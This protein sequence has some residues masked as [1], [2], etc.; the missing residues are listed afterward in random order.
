MAEAGKKDLPK[1]ETVAKQSVETIYAETVNCSKSRAGSINAGRA[2][3]DHSGIGL[4]KAQN[5]QQSN[6]GNAVVVAKNLKTSSVR[7]LIT[8][9][10][11]IEGNVRTVLD[12]QGAAI[13][14]VVFASVFMFFRII[15]RLCFR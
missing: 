7:S 14:G 15:R 3:I 5:V 10:D 11:N 13:C 8:I 2:E 4:L 12:K 1:E 9:S 6:C